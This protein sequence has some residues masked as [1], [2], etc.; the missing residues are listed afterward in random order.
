VAS[1]PPQSGKHA[2]D[3][4]FIEVIVRHPS[5][6]FFAPIFG[7]SSLPASGRAVAG[8]FKPSDFVMMSLRGGIDSTISS[9]GANAIVNGSACTRG[10]FKV[11][12]NFTVNGESVA[13]QGFDGG[14]QPTSSGGN[15]T[16]G[17]SCV[18]PDYGLPTPPTYTAPPTDGRTCIPAGQCPNPPQAGDNNLLSCPVTGDPPLQV[19]DTGGLVYVNCG[20]AQS[21]VQIYNPR[22]LVS[23]D[24]SNHAGVELMGASPGDTG[25]G[26]FQKVGVFD[27]NSGNP[28]NCTSCTRLIAKPGYYDVIDG[29]GFG[30]SSVAANCGSYRATVCFKPGLYLISTGFIGGNNTDIAS[31][32]SGPV[33]TGGG[34]SIVAGITFSPRGSGGGN[35]GL[36]L[37]CCAPDANMMSNYVLLYHLGGCNLPYSYSGQSPMYQ[38]PYAADSRTIF[39]TWPVAT[40]PAAGAWTCPTPTTSSNSFPINEMSLQGNNSTQTYNGSVYSPYQ[41]SSS[42]VPPGDTTFPSRCASGSAAYPSGAPTSGGGTRLPQFD[43]GTTGSLANRYCIQLGGGAIAING[44][45]IAPDIALN[46]NGVTVNPPAGSNARGKQPYLAE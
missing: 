25:P 23:L 34:V 20:A 19:T 45:L 32:T 36:T 22:S 9:G 28:A 46:G 39:P 5:P 2:G 37:D 31:Q 30:G 38:P 8:G 41:C 24:P 17:A 3:L 26:I 1:V 43:C 18:D 12:G 13:N 21:T 33:P 44:R 40:Y 42:P 10:Q 11:N 27:P 35:G 15:V 7:I 14:S 16:G 29:R 4:T 6:T